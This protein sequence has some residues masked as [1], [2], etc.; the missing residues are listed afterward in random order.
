MIINDVEQLLNE[1]DVTVM[2]TN[3]EVGF[4]E[5]KV[6]TKPLM[7]RGCRFFTFCLDYK[8]PHVKN[9]ENNMRGSLFFFHRNSFKSVLLKGVFS[10]ETVDENKEAELT[11]RKYQEVL[12]HDVPMVVCFETFKV[13]LIEN[14]NLLMEII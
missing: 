14:K 2:I 5:C 9:I 1:C 7:R 12:E 3:G 13:D 6:L 10:L 8:I 11:I 4:P